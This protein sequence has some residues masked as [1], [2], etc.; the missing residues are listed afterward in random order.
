MCW[1]FSFANV[2]KR[3]EETGQYAIEYSTADFLSAL[4]G[5][6]NATTSSIAD[7]V[8]C[9]YDLAYRR[10]KQLQKSGEVTAEKIGN[11]LVWKTP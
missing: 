11:T 10:L 2:P 7:E 1:E 8:G 6:E 9:S 3:D 4:E 5:I